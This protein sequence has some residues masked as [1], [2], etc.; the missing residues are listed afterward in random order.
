MQETFHCWYI[1]IDAILVARCLGTYSML[2]PPNETGRT[3]MGAVEDV[4]P[5]VLEMVPGMIGHI[6][7]VNYCCRGRGPLEMSSIRIC[8]FL[9]TRN[10]SLPVGDS[11]IRVAQC[12]GTYVA[13]AHEGDHRSS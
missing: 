10:M 4:L 8:Q 2:P 3:T 11:A 7:R 1:C 6:L 12:M 5:T 13:L 9:S